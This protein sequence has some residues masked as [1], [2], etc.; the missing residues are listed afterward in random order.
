[1]SWILNQ[2]MRSSIIRAATNQIAIVDLLVEPET[3]RCNFRVFYQPIAPPR[4]FTLAMP[5][6]NTSYDSF[7]EEKLSYHAD[8]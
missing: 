7:S 4:E 5:R 3:G 8:S 1:M 6:M 2:E